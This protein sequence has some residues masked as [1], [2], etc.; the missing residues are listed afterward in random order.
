MAKEFIKK[1]MEQLS[2]FRTAVV[3]LPE[4]GELRAL[5][6]DIVPRVRRIVANHDEEHAEIQ[7]RTSH[8]STNSSM[9]ASCKVVY[10][11]YVNN[12]L[13]REVVHYSC[14]SLRDSLAFFRRHK[15]GL[16][17]KRDLP[18]SNS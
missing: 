5:L 11:Q 18:W 4:S 1:M 7:S 17:R 16:E 14:K 3:S 8:G 9:A 10:L 12:I 15:Q 2:Q 6:E 13:S